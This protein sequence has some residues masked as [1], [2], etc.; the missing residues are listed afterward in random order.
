MIGKIGVY[1]FNASSL[2][3][4]MDEDDEL[5]ISKLSDPLLFK[6]VTKEYIENYRCEDSDCEDSDESDKEDTDDGLVEDSDS[7]V[8]E[9]EVEGVEVEKEEEDDT[10]STQGEE[11]TKDE[12]IIIEGESGKSLVQVQKELRGEDVIPEETTV[13]KELFEED[14]DVIGEMETSKDAEKI[15]KQFKRSTNWVQKYFK[16]ENFSLEDNEGGGD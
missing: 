2:T 10:E 15:R 13:I 16:N 1:E 5:D 9:V 6:Y 11:E 4:L 8:E 3:D 12:V 7:D 14:D